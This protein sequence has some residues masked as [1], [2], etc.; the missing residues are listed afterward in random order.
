VID[1][2]RFP[3]TL[4]S[5]VHLGIIFYGRAFLH[6]RYAYHIPAQAVFVHQQ[7]IGIA[8]D[9]IVKEILKQEERA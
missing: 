7:I 2:R 4:G 1:T 8:L 6:N 3:Q 9:T 5:S